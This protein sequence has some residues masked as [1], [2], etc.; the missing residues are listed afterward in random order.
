MVPR[1]FRNCLS[2]ARP[3]TLAKIVFTMKKVSITAARAFI[4]ALFA[5]WCQTSFA[6][7]FEVDGI[8]YNV[9]SW[10]KCEVYNNDDVTGS[11]IIPETVTFEGQVYKV[12]SIGNSAFEGCSSLTSIN[13]PDGVTSI[14]YSAFDNCN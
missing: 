7:R 14:G 12:T 10:G 11:V 13:I 1:L 8:R 3:E 6:Q 4:V 5:F 9:V 2:T